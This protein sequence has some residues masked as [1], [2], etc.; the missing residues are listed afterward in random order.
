MRKLSLPGR[1]EG[2][3][4]LYWTAPIQGLVSYLG[5]VAVLVVLGGLLI[6]TWRSAA[7]LTLQGQNP[8]AE[9]ADV[10][11]ST[12]QSFISNGPR[13][14]DGDP[15]ISDGDLL[16]PR[17]TV[18]ARNRDLTA[19]FAPAGTP[20]LP[21]LGLDAADVIDVD[22]KLV[23]FSTEIDAPNGAFRS[24]DLLLTNGAVIPN[25]ALVAAFGVNFDV[26]LD[27]VK[28]V[29]SQDKVLSFLDFAKGKSRSGWLD[30]PTL[31]RDEL[32]RYNVDIW[33]STEETTRT[34]NHTPIFLDGDILSAQTGVVMVH[35]ADLLPP[36]VPAGIPARGVDFG[37]DAFA[38][39]CNGDR[40]S[41]RFSTEIT[42]HD[43]LSPA[44]HF[45]DGDLL[46]LGG[47]IVYR[48]KDLVQ[49]FKPAALDLGLDAITFPA[50]RARCVPQAL[51]F[52]TLLPLVLKLFSR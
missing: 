32:K 35:Q 43:P 24:G 33:F 3:I 47:A 37:V 14:A 18:C 50:D 15:F 13:P 26:G 11:F 19:I 51:S 52:K 5:R 20:A 46:A 45:T 36:S 22:K 48:N 10:G 17:G 44:L 12:E 49:A 29:G 34:P 40:N 25:K 30:P 6:F 9:C 4:A 28:F 1:F 2:V 27:E 42:Y 7:P 38:V 41:V 31:L 8:L 21:D 39:S 23:A 16:S